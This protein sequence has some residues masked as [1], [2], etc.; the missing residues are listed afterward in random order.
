MSEFE[1]VNDFE[2]NVKLDGVHVYSST[3]SLGNQ[4]VYAGST[5]CYNY[6]YDIPAITPS[7]SFSNFFDILGKLYHHL[8][9]SRHL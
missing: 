2:M 9:S 5:Y 6:S 1:T 3:V 8:H 4:T 7:V